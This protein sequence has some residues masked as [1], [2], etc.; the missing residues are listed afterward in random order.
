MISLPC[1]RIMNM[2]FYVS[3]IELLEKIHVIQVEEYANLAFARKL[4]GVNC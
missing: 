1:E 4:K 2:N 3:L